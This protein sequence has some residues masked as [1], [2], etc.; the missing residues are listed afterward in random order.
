MGVAAATGIQRSGAFSISIYPIHYTAVPLASSP[1]AAR[2]SRP[3]RLLQMS[4]IN[5][6]SPHVLVGTRGSGVH[7]RENALL[8]GGRQVNRFRA[9]RRVR[10]GG[11]HY[12]TILY[13]CKYIYIYVTCP[14]TS[15]IH[16]H[17]PA[18][19]KLGV[20]EPLYSNPGTQSEVDGLG[21]VATR[22][23]LAVG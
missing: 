16:R 23:P 13:Y 17:G 3:S 2:L 5:I 19:L 22:G 14:R 10:L 8:S 1:L 18:K 21:L 4:Q 11:R 6:P 20:V 9:G 12:A 7:N 15:C